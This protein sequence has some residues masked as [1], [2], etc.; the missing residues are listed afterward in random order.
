MINLF[1]MLQ[2]INTLK[3]G[4]EQPDLIVDDYHAN[5]QKYIEMEMRFPHWREM[6]D[7]F[8]KEHPEHLPKLHYLREKGIPI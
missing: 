7:N 3:K 4:L 2:T 6:L 8:L 1:T 5:P